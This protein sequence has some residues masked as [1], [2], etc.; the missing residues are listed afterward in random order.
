H[1]PAELEYLI[2]R[3]C[4]IKAG[5]VQEDER[6][7]G[8][9]RILNFGHTVGHALEAVTHYRRFLHGE[10]VAHGMRAASRIA[11]RAG[12]LPRTARDLIDASIAGVGSLPA[13]NTLELD[14]I[15]SAMYRDKKVQA[16]RTVFVLPVAIGEVVIRSD[17]SP[18][19][20]RAALKDTLR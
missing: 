13:A 4:A 7:N 15:I 5:I 12:L 14:D 17:V 20:V 6:E 1:E 8:L 16:G 11:E 9:R 3:C 19:V 18:Q 2:S 10:A